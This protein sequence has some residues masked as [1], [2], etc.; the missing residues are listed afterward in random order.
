MEAGPPDPCTGPGEAGGKNGTSIVSV[1]PSANSFEPAVIAANVGTDAKPTRSATISTYR[2]V[3]PEKP[4][5]ARYT[6]SS[7]FRMTLS[8]G[9]RS[10]SGW[11][12]TA[13]S[14]PCEQ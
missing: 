1:M 9:T 13:G 11:S 2:R 7:R 3:G 4:E 12:G 14:P 10:S 5:S 8:G 6:P